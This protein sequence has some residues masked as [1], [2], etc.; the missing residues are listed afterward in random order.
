MSNDRVVDESK[1]AEARKQAISEIDERSPRAVVSTSWTAVL[2]DALI[3][4]A[5]TFALGFAVGMAGATNEVFL[6]GANAILLTACFM[7]AGTFAKTS[8]F[9]HLSKVAVLVWLLGII[10]VLAS[11][12]NIAEWLLSLLLILLSMSL[13]SAL[14]YFFSKPSKQ[15]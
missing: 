5:L 1:L 4:V 10:N 2:R 8:R 7:V 11:Q 9:S 12:V 14:S 13:G 15:D 6:V 3:I